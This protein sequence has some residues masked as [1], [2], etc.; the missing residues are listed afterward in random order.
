MGGREGQRLLRATNRAP[1]AF[2]KVTDMKGIPAQLDFGS[3]RTFEGRRKIRE[4]KLPNTIQ[5]RGEPACDSSRERNNLVRQIQVVRMPQPMIHVSRNLLTSTRMYSIESPTENESAS[6]ATALCVCSGRPSHHPERSSAR[7][8]RIPPGHAHRKHSSRSG[9]GPGSVASQAQRGVAEG[10]TD[11][12][13]QRGGGGGEG[14]E[15]TDG[16]IGEGRRIWGELA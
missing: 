15:W 2:S 10:T 13:N 7:C 1:A 11:E 14:G 3:V 8:Q 12:N 6:S 16:R 4:R 5:L 9:S